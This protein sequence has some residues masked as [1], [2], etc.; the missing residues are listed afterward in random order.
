M[1]L[2]VGDE[3]VIVSRAGS[4]QLL[5]TSLDFA[6]LANPPG[7]QIPLLVNLMFE[8]LLGPGLLDGIAIEQRSPTAAKVVP[9]RPAVDASG[10]GLSR[11]PR[12]LRDATRPLLALAT[13]LLLWEI[14]ALARQCWPLGRPGASRNASAMRSPGPVAQPRAAASKPAGGSGE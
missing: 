11:E 1:L 10:D 4:A 13:L 7:P 14:G 5:E 3:P 2:A 8:Q 9:S 6:A 12:L